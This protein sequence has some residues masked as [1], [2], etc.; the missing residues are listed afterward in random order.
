CAKGGAVVIP[1]LYYF[2]HW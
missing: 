1:T 2:D